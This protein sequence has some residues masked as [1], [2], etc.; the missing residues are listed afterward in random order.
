MPDATLR[1][2]RRHEKKIKPENREPAAR[3]R[4]RILYCSA[5]R[6]LAEVTQVVAAET[7]TSIP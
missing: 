7:R 6:R 3:D 4:D 1:E 2:E 5:F